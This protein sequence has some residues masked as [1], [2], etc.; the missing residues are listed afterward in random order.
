MKFVKIITKLAIFSFLI[1]LFFCLVMG[2]YCFHLTKDAHLSTEKLQLSTQKIVFCDTFGK[3]IESSYLNLRENASESE[4]PNTLKNAFI[5]IE[6]KRFYS[7]NGIDVKRMLGASLNN[8]KSGKYK[9]GASTITQQLIKNTHLNS[10]KTIK[11]KLSEIKLAL[12]LER[13]YDKNAIITMYLNHIY[14]GE[15]CYGVKSASHRYFAKELH[16]LSASECATLAAIVKAPTYYSPTSNAK[17][18]K[19]RRDLILKEM[20]KQQFIDEKTYLASIQEPLTVLKDN[21]AHAKDY[22]KEVMSEVEQILPFPLFSYGNT[23]TIYTGLDPK[24]QEILEDLSFTLPENAHFSA[25]ALN[26]QQNLVS[27]FR[28]TIGMPY[29]Q[30]GST[31]KPFSVYGPAIEQD[32]IDESTLILDEP[33]SYSGYKPHNYGEQYH[34]YVSA[35]YALAHSLNVPAVKILDG[36]GVKSARNTLKKLGFHI[37]EKDNSLPLA[38]GATNFGISLKDITNAYSTLAKGGEYEK[39]TFV[40]QILADSAPI[41][42]KNSGKSRVFSQETSFLLTDMLKESVN[43]GTAKKLSYLPFETAAKTGTVGTATGNTDAYTISYTEN[44]ALGVWLGAKEGEMNN[45]VSGGNLPAT[46]SMEIWQELN[47]KT[48]VGA[49]PPPPSE[50]KRVALHKPSYK[51]ELKEYL[52]SDTDVAENKIFTYYKKNRVPPTLN[53]KKPTQ[54]A[55]FLEVKTDNF[56]VCIILCVKEDGD[57]ALFREEKTQNSPPKAEQLCSLTKTD[58]FLF[59]DETATQ[60]KSYRYFIQEITATSTQNNATYSNYITVPYAF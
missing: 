21:S 9:E 38:L 43:S 56:N 55:E 47:K 50:I 29:R 2:I 51:N 57:F 32:F 44:Y 36:I 8:I 46:L 20:R 40:Q 37:T 23:I 18:C 30:T 48:S 54:K 34:G 1:L 31:L 10:E 16:E 26:N 14:F 27:A 22:L 15:N 60:G 45:S 17:R 11:R 33:I 25:I 53:L 3:E 42:I 41:Y 13:K 6:D 49:M 12:L 39:C 4:I 58:H 28:S 52:A 24:T 19:E 7:H 35:K 59:L 5:A